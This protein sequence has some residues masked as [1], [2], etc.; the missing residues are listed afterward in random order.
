MTHAEYR[1]IHQ[2]IGALCKYCPK[3]EVE[4]ERCNILSL[5]DQA[6][7]KLLDNITKTDTINI[8]D[9]KIGDIIKNPETNTIGE[10]TDIFN[11]NGIC[12]IETTNVFTDP[13]S[14]SEEFEIEVSDAT[15]IDR[16]GRF[17]DN[18]EPNDFL[19]YGQDANTGIALYKYVFVKKVSGK[20]PLAFKNIEEVITFAESIVDEKGNRLLHDSIINIMRTRHYIPSSIL[21]ALLNEIFECNWF[22]G[23][24]NI[25]ISTNFDEA[26]LEIKGELILTVVADTDENAILAARKTEKHSRR[27]FEDNNVK[28]EAIDISALIE[29]QFITYQFI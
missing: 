26:S 19:L 29:K 4:C 14:S 1:K 8:K 28:S 20:M 21:P 15:K 9:L 25:Q 2:S 6:T 18:T 10:V 12:T 22:D 7:Y 5:R 3:D 17:D 24:N 16:Y 23:I 11:E 27:G 13:F